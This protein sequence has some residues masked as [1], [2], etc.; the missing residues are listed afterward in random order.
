MKNSEKKSINAQKQAAERTQNTAVF[1]IHSDIIRSSMPINLRGSGRPPQEHTR[2]RECRLFFLPTEPESQKA[3][4]SDHASIAQAP[5]TAG[6]Y[7][8][9]AVVGTAS[10]TWRFGIQG[11]AF[12]LSLF[13]SDTQH[14]R[15]FPRS[16]LKKKR[17]LGPAEEK[18]PQHAHCPIDPASFVASRRQARLN[19]Y[20]WRETRSLIAPEQEARRGFDFVGHA[21]K[22]PGLAWPR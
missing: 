13:K 2:R 20:K 11:R 18:S 21:S 5:P 12:S 16:A 4:H 22:S 7:H 10:F 19:D 3:R 8:S 9:K 14:R 6:S 15:V 1:I 17:Q